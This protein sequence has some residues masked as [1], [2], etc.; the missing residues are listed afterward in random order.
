MLLD[1]L[2]EKEAMEKLHWQL[3]RRTKRRLFLFSNIHITDI[4]SIVIFL[5][6]YNR[7]LTN[8]SER[9]S[10]SSFHIKETQDAKSRSR[11]KYLRKC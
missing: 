9:T 2:S 6:F 10:I 8:A 3:T 11:N 5:R 1:L 4:S 7:K